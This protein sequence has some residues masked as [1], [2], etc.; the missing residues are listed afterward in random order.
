MMVL[1]GLLD[2]LMVTFELETMASFSG[3]SMVIWLPE[4]SRTSVGVGLMTVEVGSDLV[5]EIVGIAVVDDD[6]GDFLM[7]K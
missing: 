7:A 5:T 3:E 4:L 6:D 1:L 2:P